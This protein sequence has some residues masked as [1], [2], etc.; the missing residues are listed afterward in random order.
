MANVKGADFGSLRKLMKL[1]GKAREDEL[2]AALAPE[3]QQLFKRGMASDWTPVERHAEFISAVAEALYPNQALSV[4]SLGR[5]LA[6]HS[7]SGVY[8]LFLRIP[9][10]HFIIGKAASVWATYYDTGVARVENVAPGQGDF[11][12]REFSDLPQALRRT[13]T[14]HVQMLLEMAGARKPHVR[15]QDE[16][17][18]AWRWCA[19][20]Q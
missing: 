20:W 7:F 8:R 18:T 5:E 10:V 9:S 17:P 1:L 13:T 14:G 11:V 4:E 6:R 3:H 12:V 2:V 16:D 15:L 19:S